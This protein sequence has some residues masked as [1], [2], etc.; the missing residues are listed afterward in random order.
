V[1][2]GRRRPSRW[3][4]PSTLPP[5]YAPWIAD[6]LDGPLPSESEATCESCAMWPPAGAAPAA[7]RFFHPDTKCCT[8]VPDLP[9]FLVGRILDDA[10]PALAEGR[11]SV[12]RRLDARVAVS[13]L[14]IGSPPVQVLLYRHGSA[15]GFGRARALRCPH[16]RADLGGACGIWRHRNGVCSTWFCK[17][18]RG[19]TGQRFWQG[20]DQLLWIVER[21][22]TRWCVLQI[23][24]DAEVLAR[25]FPRGADR[26]PAGGNLDREALDGTVSEA[27]YR[28]QWGSWQGRERELFRRAAAL[29]TGLRWADVERIGGASVAAFARVVAEAHRRHGRDDIPERLTVGAMKIAVAGRE[30]VRVVTYS[31]YDPLELPRLLVDALSYFDG[32]PTTEA[33]RRIRAE[34]RINLQPDLL[35]R[36]VDFG[37]LVS[38]TATGSP[39]DFDQPK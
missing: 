7:D 11:A 24:V 32:R 30:R 6:L 8:Y 19:V 33:L 20:L 18:G 34:R 16:Y 38:S 21:E 1:A 9:N 4:P 39:G 5:L 13:P 2:G 15:A 35:G 10:D 36:L 14:G 31:E 12:E 26:G 3:Q 23:G 28:A 29:V 17:H 27:T 22:L 25:L 37:I